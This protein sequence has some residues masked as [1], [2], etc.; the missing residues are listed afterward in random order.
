MSS[1]P[2]IVL[3]SYIY[4]RTTYCRHKR[5]IKYMETNIKHRLVYD[6]IIFLDNSSDV[7]YWKKLGASVFDERFYLVHAGRDDLIVIRFY[8]HLK[9]GGC[10][11]YPYFWRSLYFIPTLYKNFNYQTSKYYY[12]DSDLYITTTKMIDCLKSIQSGFIS[13]WDK[14]H[15][16]PESIF[17]TIC[18]DS[19]KIL[20]EDSRKGFLGRAGELAETCIPFT[21][22]NKE[23]HGGRFAETNQQQTDD[24]NFIG[25]VDKKYRIKF[26]E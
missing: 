26:N 8:D 6:K 4:D 13:F 22:V 18:S 19:V 14:V 2:N 25:Q 1:T 21:D 7:K 9:R 15:Q 10:L 17:F 16:F 11:D 12:I 24:M 20:E 23:I 5:W 3:P